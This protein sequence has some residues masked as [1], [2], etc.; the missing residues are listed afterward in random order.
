[1]HDTNRYLFIIFVLLLASAHSADAS[2]YDFGVFL[3]LRRLFCKLPLFRSLP[4]LCSISCGPTEECALGTQ[5]CDKFSCDGDEG[6]C[7]MTTD[8]CTFD[9]RPVCG[10]D[11]KTYGND[12]G[13]KS[14]GVS[15]ASLGECPEDG[16]AGP[17]ICGAGADNAECPAENQFCDLPVGSCDNADA[18]RGECVELEEA[19][20]DDVDAPVCGC[21]GTTYSNDCERINARVSKSNDGDCSEACGVTDSTA[22]AGSNEFCDL[23]AGNCDNAGAM[24][25]CVEVAPQCTADYSPVCGCDGKTY[26]NDCTRLFARVNKEKEGEC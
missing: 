2:R 9:Y 5:F 14:A 24:G 26:G 10:C 3:I 25:V 18:R 11:G 22:C 8:R 21:D 7:T 16:V 20:C 15:R 19:G 1:M 6:V 12:C 4:F 23:P 13:R 17:G